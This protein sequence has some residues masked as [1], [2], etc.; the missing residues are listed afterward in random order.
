MNAK[1]SSRRSAL[2]SFQ[3]QNT[4]LPSWLH[5]KSAGG[6]TFLESRSVKKSEIQCS[7]FSNCPKTVAGCIRLLLL[8]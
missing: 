7:Q 6:R 4:Y 5:D 3:F 1:G 2:L 8:L